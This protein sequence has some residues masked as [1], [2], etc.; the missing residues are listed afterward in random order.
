MVADTS[1]APAPEQWLKSPLR[2]SWLCDPLVLDSAFQMASLWCYEQ[3]GSV[4]L[5]SHAH[6]YRQF[7]S[8]FP[9]DGV[10]VVLEVR[11]ATDKKLRGDF[12]FLD[13][14]RV[15]VARLTGY[16]AVMDPILNRAFKPEKPVQP[17]A[18]N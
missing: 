2:N 13:A 12:I 3:R 10:T 17:E 9:A 5:P 6:S 7:R 14:G 15:V 8:T 4:S 16:E 11:E 18:A 1:G